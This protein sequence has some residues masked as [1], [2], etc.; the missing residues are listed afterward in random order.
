MAINILI[1]W[2]LTL[3]SSALVAWG[4]SEVLGFFFSP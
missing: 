3:P 2:V 1:A 4:A